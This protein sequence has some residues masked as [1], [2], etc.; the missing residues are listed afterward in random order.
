M[1]F[2]LDG[3]NIPDELVAL[4]ERGQTI[5][6]CG[7]GI[8]RPVGLPSFHDLVQKVYD[9]L[10][11]DWSLHIAG[12]EVMRVGGS[13]A[14]QYDRALRS[15]EKRLAASDLPRNRGMRERVRT[16]VRRALTP[17]AGANLDNHF[18]L[19]ELSRNEEGSSRII[20]TNFDTLFERAWYSVH[21]RPIDSHA[22]A[23]MPQPK[24]SGFAGVLHLRGRLADD[25]PE[26]RLPET[27]LVLTSVE[28]GDAYL[29]AGWASRYIYDVVRA[30]TVVLVGY[31]ADDPPMRY[32][33]EVLEAD[34]ERYADLHQVF[35]FASC[36]P[37]NEEVDKA[38]WR[39][40]GVEP[41]LYRPNGHDHSPLYD[42]LREW[43]VYASDPTAWRLGELRSIFSA[44]P[45]SCGADELS[46]CAALLGHG[47]AA[48]LLGD[49]SPDPD[50]LPVLQERRIFLRERVHPGIWIG[51]RLDSPEMIRACIG[52]ARLSEESIWYIERAIENARE[53]LSSVRL[54]AW[55]LI[56]KWKRTPHQRDASHE[57]YGAAR[58]IRRGDTGHDSRQII[59]R[60]L[61]PR[62]EVSK[63]FRRVEEEAEHEESLRDLLSIGFDSSRH[64]PANEI[65]NAWPQDLEREIALFRVLERALLE[66]LEEASDVGYLYEWDR[67][68]SDVPSIAPHQQNA[69]RSG[70]YPIVSALAGLW[71]RISSRDRDKAREVVAAWMSSP[72]LLVRRLYLFA[73]CSDTTFTPQEAWAAVST[74]DDR[75]MW[76]GD[77]Q[78]EVMR[79]V[80]GRWSQFTPESRNTFE[81]R[82]REGIPRTL[83]PA[84]AI[85]NGDEWISVKESAAM[86]RLGRLRGVNPGI[87]AESQ[88]LLDEIAA[89]HPRWVPSEGDRDAFSVWLESH[90]GPDGEPELL[91]NVMDAAL[92]AEA[93]RLQSERQFDQGDIWRMFCDSDPERALRGLKL[94]ADAGRWEASAWRD[95][96][97]V[98]TDKGDALVQ[99][100]L[101]ES[102]ANMAA[103]LL[104]E[105]VPAAASWVQKRR[106]LLTGDAPN[107]TRFLEL[108]DKLADVTYV[109]DAAAPEEEGKL[110]E[111]A[112]NDPAGV[113]AAT[114]IDYIA[115]AKPVA[116]S[117]FN[118][119]QSERLTRAANAAGLPGV[120]AR[121]T[122]GR[123]LPYLEWIDHA[124]VASTLFPYLNWTQPHAVAMWQARAFN[125]NTGTARLFNS[126]KALMLDSFAQSA[127]TEDALEGLMGQ[128]L[129]VAFA[130][131]RH[132][133]GEYS[134]S[135]AEIRRA[136]TVGP[137]ALRA[138][139]AWQLWRSMGD[140]QG[141]PADKAVRWRQV[142]GPIFREIWPLDVRFRDENTS[143]NLV[144]LTLESGAAFD[145]VVNTVIDFVIPYQMYFIAHTFRLEPAHAEVIR[146]YPRSALRLA[147]ALID[148]DVHPVPNDLHEF[149]RDCVASD[150]GISSEAAYVRLFGLRRQLGA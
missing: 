78:V 32:L 27:D 36:E 46:R 84:R 57:W 82:V 37:D 52:L 99:L 67:A 55:Q 23:A 8:S 134:I 29:R 5:F 93:M 114:M 108:W 80:A 6:V 51:T 120:F 104:I 59:R 28:F 81:A 85:G 19:L 50:W 119:A 44:P 118:Q 103:A 61:Q 62:L 144:L 11:E 131:R 130:H 48:Q 150:S 15:L 22:H 86:K 107:A 148:P 109:S 123:A 26:L 21:R 73:L 66:T 63:A 139:V 33:L 41:I 94:E 124:W 25:L 13:L 137:P 72:Y 128:F 95:L 89:R 9:E 45:D 20:T 91:A 132:E 105:L 92:V 64:P 34:R 129:S 102:L 12:R 24:V 96:I 138:N 122:L 40:K 127:M 145:E 14:H 121:V 7:A 112:L 60:M 116:D 90:W 149:L 69:H 113:L 68:N 75:F 71:E 65:L 97:W 49:L 56:L 142:V 136:L 111:R 3:P 30:H 117:G 147:N 79:L 87:S 2:R 141:E 16:A 38:L 106:G 58:H 100:D 47:D 146:L 133:A 101:M 35:A 10:G 88:T 43:K 83:L 53:T 31:A 110:L 143:R 70:F 115:E 39:A 126:V 125:P 140:A 42:S 135:L 17:P 1:R 74:L 4:Q 18:A 98:A 54:K 76:T 77:A